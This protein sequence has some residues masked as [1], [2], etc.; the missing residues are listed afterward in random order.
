[1]DFQTQLLAPGTTAKLSADAL[2]LVL[3]GDT[4]PADLDAPLA[5][6]VADAVKLGDLAQKPGKT[7]YLRQVPGVKAPRVVFAAC[8]AA[9]PKSLKAAFAEA[10]SIEVVNRTEI[11]APRSTFV[12]SARGRK[13]TTLG[14]D[15]VRTSSAPPSTAR[16]SWSRTPSTTSR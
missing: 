10:R 6:S 14:A 16:P 12:A 1:M 4:L 2:L 13:R 9:T 15:R 8:G 11:A 5:D 7:V 3:V